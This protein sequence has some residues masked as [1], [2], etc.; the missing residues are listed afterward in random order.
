MWMSSGE[1]VVESGSFDACELQ[2]FGGL[3]FVVEPPTPAIEAIRVT[4]DRAS[5]FQRGGVVQS[6]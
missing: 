6:P 2:S 3:G 5:T 1:Q 4:D